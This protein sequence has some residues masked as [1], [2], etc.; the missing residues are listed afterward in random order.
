MRPK[1]LR[2]RNP[3]PLNLLKIVYAKKNSEVEIKKYFFPP[4]FS[5][6]KIAITRQKICANQSEKKRSQPVLDC[7]RNCTSQVHIKKINNAKRMQK[8]MADGQEYEMAQRLQ[9]EL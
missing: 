7:K 9:E 6:S 4:T 8:N 1:E 3:R 2:N 5:R